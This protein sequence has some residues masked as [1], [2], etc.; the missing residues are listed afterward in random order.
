MDL[1]MIEG[2]IGFAGETLSAEEWVDNVRTAKIMQEMINGEENSLFFIILASK[3]NEL[4]NY[5]CKFCSCI[6][7]RH[8]CIYRWEE[9]SLMYWK[10][11]CM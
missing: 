4:L 2:G 10:H 9:W 6:L 1:H 8:T 7:Y 3:K 11:K 5:I